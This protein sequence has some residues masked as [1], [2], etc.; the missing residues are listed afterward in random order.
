MVAP[1]RRGTL[2]GRKER[3]H[4]DPTLILYRATASSR[5]GAKLIVL[6]LPACFRD[7]RDTYFKN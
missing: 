3:V 2:L 4:F 6:L 7:H 5:F 1:G